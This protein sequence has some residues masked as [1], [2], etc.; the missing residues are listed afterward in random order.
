MHTRSFGTLTLLSLLT[1][2]AAAALT[3]EVSQSWLSPGI[4]LPT[5]AKAPLFISLTP[6]RAACERAYGRDWAGKCSRPFGLYAARVQGVSLSPAI[7]GTWRW[8]SG[9]RLSFTPDEAW[10][11]ATRYS[12]SLG[13]MA[14]PETT[15][16][17]ESN[18][19]FSTP[20]LTM[21]AK[22]ARFWLDPT[23][24]GERAV[25]FEAEF[26]TAVLDR[27]AFEKA[28]RLSAPGAEGLKL[29]TPVFVWNYD[30]T[31][32]Y[33]RVPV[34]ALGER[35]AVLRAAFPGT[36]GAWSA[37]DRR[38]PQVKA[39]YETAE[40][41]LQIPAAGE[42]YRLSRADLAPTKTDAL[43]SVYELTLRPTLLTTPEALMRAL[44]VAALPS[45]LNE[46]AVSDTDWSKAPAIDAEA[47]ARSTP[48]SV[49][50]AQ[51]PAVP[52]DTIR[53][54]LRTKSGSFLHVSLPSGFGPAPQATLQKP[55]HTVLHAA[56]PGASVGFLQPGS[57]MTL[58]GT[59]TF[60]LH[61]EGVERIRWR[62]ER[63]RDPFFAVLSQQYRAHS[64]VT[65]A[66]AY[67]EAAEGV[68][69]VQKDQR[70]AS[71]SLD[72]AK[73]AQGP[74]GLFQ[75]TLTG[76]KRAED[77]SWKPCAQASKR[78]LVTDTALIAKTER[79]GSHR[80]FA[81]DLQ[82]GAPAEGLE[83]TLLGA[84]GVPLQT[85]ATDS[86][87]SAA[88]A[89]TEGLVREKAPSAV[90]AK[91]AK[92]GD[93]AWVSLADFSNI[94][95]L[96][97]FDVN[98]R[99]IPPAGLT[100]LVFAERG[101]FRPGETLR[102]GMIVK[103][104]D[105][106][107]LP[108][109]LPVEVRLTDAA[110][111]LLH[112]E[113]KTL[114][115]E[116]LAEV[117]WETPKDI[118]PGRVRIDVLTG[119]TV[120]A[121]SVVRVEDFTPEAMTL[122]AAPENAVLG[123]LTP[124]EGRVNLTLKNNFGQGA[125]GRE[126]RGTV[127]A[128]SPG[129]L[130]FPGFDDYVFADPLPA[131]GS[132]SIKLLPLETNAEGRA[133][134]D[135]PLAALAKGTV[136]VN[137][138]FEGFE[139]AGGRA[140]TESLSLL[141]SPAR[142]ML[143]WK[144]AGTAH[145]LSWLPAG[146]GA[147]LDLVL[148]DRNLKPLS[149]ES[150]QVTL[151]KRQYVTELATDSTGALRYRDRAVETAA[152]SLTLQTDADGRAKLDVDTAVP[153]GFTAVIRSASG[154]VLARLPYFVAGDDLRQGLADSLPAAKMHLKVQKSAYTSG[155][156]A[157]V[158]ILSPFDGF[159]LLTFESDR[160]A[161]HQW[162]AV[163]RGHNRAAVPVPE[164]LTG[165]AWLS[166]SL[167][168][169][170]ADAARFLKAY[171]RAVV[172][173]TVNARQHTVNFTLEAP[174]RTADPKAVSVT[175]RADRPGKAF[176][177]AADDGILAITGYKTPS[178]ARSLLEDRALQVTTRQTLDGLMPEG[179]RLPGASPYGGGFAADALGAA[180]TTNPFRRTAEK[181][182]VWWGGLVDVSPEGTPLTITLPAEFS[183]RIR[184]MAAGADGAGAGA[185]ARDITVRQPVVLTP[186]FP[187]FAAPG[188]RFRG[189][190]TVSAEEAQKGT[191]NV[192]APAA[193]TGGLADTPLSLAAE[194]E[195]T[196][197]FDMTAGPLPGAADIAVSF[198]TDGET[199]TRTVPI[200][201][202][203]HR[204]HFTETHWSTFTDRSEAVLQVSESLYPHEAETVFTVSAVPVPA[205]TALMA[206]L[207]LTDWSG[208]LDRIAAA[209]PRTALL[210][211][212]ALLREAGLSEA[213][214]RKETLRFADGAYSAIRDSLRWQGVSRWQWGEPDL[215]ATAFALDF[216]L[217][218]R[219][220][221]LTVPTELIYEVRDALGRAVDAADARS[222][223]T[224]RAAAYA[225]AMLTKEGTLS[226]ERIESLRTTM[227][228]AR[229]PWESDVTAAYLA[230][231]Y[232]MMRMESEA[233][234]LL[235]KDILVPSAER[236][237]SDSLDGLTALCAA[238]RLLD[239]PDASQTV[240]DA[241]RARDPQTLSVT[242][243]AQGAALLTESADAP[244]AR[245]A[246][247]GVTLSCIERTADFD[248]KDALTR[249]S[250][251]VT[252]SAPGCRRVTVKSSA[253][254][255]GLYWQ[256]LK[257]GYAR[258]AA[259]K[260]V[261]EGL[262]IEKRL[263]DADGRPL[264]TVKTGDVVTVELR[265]RRSR[266]SD[267]VP[268][269]VTDLLPGGFELLPSEEALG[270]GMLRTIRA[271]DR[272]TLLAEVGTD[273]A[274]YTY[275]MRAVSAGS[276]AVPPAEAADTAAPDVHARSTSMR[277]T[278]TD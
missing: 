4:T 149:G 172:P 72:E 268:V 87:G 5:S 56:D 114:T 234:A 27:R 68:L 211:K 206:S 264:Q 251:S 237:W 155:E 61:A 217:T 98:G 187:A 19:G 204:A 256:T 153:G 108:A 58:S 55:W 17:T 158:D 146:S 24:G 180:L 222:L 275:R 82:T 213:D 132:D 102:A 236:T 262:E 201:I 43:E 54:T 246:L 238:A 134:A 249:G 167:V 79:T 188:D 30:G 52:S 214:F 2:E 135:L 125:A 71:L 40:I 148:V 83:V 166:A 115:P 62:I 200:S 215:F 81:A 7:K 70:F 53:L 243:R 205:V 254:L 11:A 174:E 258:D 255:R 183:G 93:V 207:T 97:D 230:A 190:V 84:N 276:F 3:G 137:A 45:R 242:A 94:D 259:S 235:Q 85:A 64:T 120:V 1:M 260:P 123:W 124:E 198:K 194:G 117:L 197:T 91:N 193:L 247:D 210:G 156:T 39:G 95:D 181:A 128:Y 26:S 199:R 231:A 178:P 69:N 90:I 36:A 34:K 103:T 66:A 101:L 46:S 78:L 232:R 141:V 177:W 189:A 173:V 20:P 221:G 42:L 223:P 244:A 32:V 63:F 245:T 73:F 233:A 38:H 239:T 48:V 51:D 209:L 272:I 121:S 169:G 131:E 18:P 109:A 265:A 14:L 136:R 191:L 92:T 107:P 220:N 130:R 127:S 33:I 240:L 179:I 147:A 171:A 29:G 104:A 31:R 218:A 80:V 192:T 165:R 145:P 182:A 151:A 106:S 10:P 227:T 77:G 122:R 161:G 76:E 9:N 112:S 212:P 22:N 208:T 118:L 225:L 270:T 8:A 164:G 21:S 96:S 196:R 28:F 35:A 216:L 168:R 16:L 119:K 105:F 67:A 111:R 162:T 23:V 74:S 176:V 248:A 142:A 41:T 253:S 278:V 50:S 44:R 65:D 203:P 15:T 159:A 271:E 224:A 250:V 170:T 13:G 57:M 47:L 12:V 6:D 226:A 263:L 202:R 273:E 154:D 152:S 116:G 266:G 100:G 274:R 257:A 252:L 185:A 277:V 126:V 86:T 261:H 110:G 139:A 144:T 150:L 113:T 140:A 195:A 269:A 129:E 60:T 99:D 89:T 49:E 133:A 138:Q 157:E 229:L 186:Q 59:R 228:R 219:E 267:D 160:I 241:L 88:F 163:K 75:V 25:S 143:G 37:P 175:L 184:L